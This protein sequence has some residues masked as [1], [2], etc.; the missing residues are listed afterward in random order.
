MN[1]LRMNFACGDYDR[2]QALKEGRI[3]VPGI[4][5]NLIALPPEDIFFRMLKHRE[6]E[7][8]EMSLSSYTLSRQAGEPAFVAIP[9]FVSR[10]FRHSC[11]YVNER[12]G[13]RKPSDLRGKKVGCPEYQMTATVWIRGMLSDYYELPVDSV[14]Y[15]TGGQEQAGRQEK[16]PLNLPDNISVV[17]IHQEKTL[18]QML[19]DGEIDALY[20]A[21][22]P[23]TYAGE[24]GP[25]RR[26]FEDY[27]REERLYY[28]RSRIF[29]IMHTVAMR[30]DVYRQN[31]WAARSLL[32]A[33]EEAK[34]IACD[35]LHEFATLKVMMPWLGSDLRDTKA[36]MGADFWPY[37]VEPNRLVLETFLRYFHEQGLSAERLG[38]EDMFAPETLD[39]ARI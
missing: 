19:L 1:R 39:A 28:D 17:P 9:A 21:R 16:I 23:S 14:T 38:I 31:R 12:S 35:A 13:I 27:G 29:P 11:V 10:T 6:F 25:I 4:D 37:G 8:A 24:H 18:A 26:L 36:R 30:S 3:D 33:L 22:T 7:A 34:Q 20:T 2:V 5:L 32:A 15:F